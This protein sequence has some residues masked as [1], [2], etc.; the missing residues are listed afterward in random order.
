VTINGEEFFNRQGDLVDRALALYSAQHSRAF[1]DR[2]MTPKTAALKYKD[3]ARQLR[4][5]VEFVQIRV[6]MLPC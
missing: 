5:N 3:V 1:C 4:E 2:T 6:F